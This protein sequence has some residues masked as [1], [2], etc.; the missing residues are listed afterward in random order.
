[1]DG[2]LPHYRHD[3]QPSHFRGHKGGTDDGYV[4]LSPDGDE[5]AGVLPAAFDASSKKQLSVNG[6]GGAG[7]S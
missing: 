6:G 4:S 1:M 3:H 2:Y 5:G 7:E